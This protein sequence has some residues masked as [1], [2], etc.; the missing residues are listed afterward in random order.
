CG[1][2]HDIVKNPADQYV[3]DFVHNLNPINML[4]A[5]DVMQP[6]LGQTAAGMSVSAT[7]RAATPLIDILSRDGADNRTVLDDADTARLA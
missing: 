1:T 3:A 6:G 4:T 2:P 7:A 5:A